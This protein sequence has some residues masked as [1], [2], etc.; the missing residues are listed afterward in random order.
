MKKILL[1]AAFA[2]SSLSLF[3]AG[4]GVDEKVLEAFNK[5]FR[6]AQD[7]SWTEMEDTYQVSFKQNT[8]TSKITYDRRG[9]IVKTL[10]YYFEEQLP[11]LV[12]SRIKN[13]YSGKS[14]HGVVEVSSEAGTFYHITLEDEKNW[15]EIKADN[16]GNLSVEKKFRKA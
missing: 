9:N 13:K 8:I 5:T 2:I 6:N 7:V 4:P 14:V 12:L 10:R 1:A 15:M 11:L 3:A 16:F